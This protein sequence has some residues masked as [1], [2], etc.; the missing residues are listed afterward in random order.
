MTGLSGAGKSTIAYATEGRLLADGRMAT[1]L[2]GDDLRRGLSRDLG[3]DPAARSE[4][5]RRAA[6]VAVLLSAAGVVALVALISPFAEDR[7]RARQL[8][9]ASGLPFIEVYVAT[10][11]SEC[12][13][14]D[15]KGLYRH[16]R[17]G[18]LKDLTGVDGPYEPPRAPD[19]VIGREGESV[20]QAV[21]RILAGVP[22]VR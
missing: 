16:A 22:R 4:N 15:P 14:R 6:E 10:S 20:N 9:A 18:R 12:E 19:L 1:V 11:L 5:A 8:H 3:M 13:R 2:D 17:A 21:T 7:E